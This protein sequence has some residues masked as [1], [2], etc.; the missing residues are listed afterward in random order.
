[1]GPTE[2]DLYMFFVNKQGTC[3]GHMPRTGESELIFYCLINYNFDRFRCRKIKFYIL[4]Y[5][6]DYD[7]CYDYVYYYLGT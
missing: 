4:R 2:N 5:D 3:S 1:M 7:Y 6:Y